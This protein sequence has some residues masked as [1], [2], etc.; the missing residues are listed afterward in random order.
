MSRL[1][2]V[3]LAL[4]SASAFA[5]D[6]PRTEQHTYARAYDVSTPTESADNDQIVTVVNLTN[7]TFTIAAQPDV[8]RNVTITVT[9]TTP[10]ITEGTITIT[11]LDV[12]GATITEVLDMA[13]PT[14][15]FTG[16][17]VFVS[18]T[19]VVSAGAATLG[20]AGDETIIVGTGSVVAPIFCSTS[21]PL[22]GVGTV[23]TSGSS[24]TVT[25]GAGAP[26]NLLDVGDEIIV[27]DPVDETQARRVITAKASGTSVTVDSAVSWTA[28]GSSG[29]P[30]TYRDR[31]CGTSDSSGWHDSTGK[32]NKLVIL[33][34]LALSA[35][36][37]LDYFVQCR[38]LGDASTPTTLVT[39]NITQAI[40]PGNQATTFD[41]IVVPEACTALR[42][43]LKYGTT[44]T[45]GTDSISAFLRTE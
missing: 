2:A 6:T 25:A 20:G 3:L 40:V 27:T 31:T 23:K 11:G 34:V 7:T 41:P 24:T 30:F 44:D 26:F 4:F 9:D 15:T 5:A 45:S 17:K 33:H 8:P 29:I 16:T 37:G 39:G 12:N 13:G 38:G 28:N 14:L 1:L 10:T 36:G 22:R 18:V 43:G 32:G 19:S 42:V 21:A 35:T